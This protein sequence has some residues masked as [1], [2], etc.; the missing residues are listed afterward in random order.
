MALTFFTGSNLCGEHSSNES[1]PSWKR[2]YRLWSGGTFDYRDRGVKP[3]E[4]PIWGIMV[5]YSSGTTNI[6]EDSF[7]SLISQNIRFDLHG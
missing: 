3:L 6:S 5:L 4:D 2:Q 1:T 7:S